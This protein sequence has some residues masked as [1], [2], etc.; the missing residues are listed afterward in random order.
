MLA[1]KL[2]TFF[3]GLALLLP[4]AITFWIM[5]FRHQ[6]TEAELKMRQEQIFAE[7]K[8]EHDF[9]DGASEAPDDRDPV[10]AGVVAYDSM[11]LPMVPPDVWSFF[12]RRWVGLVGLFC[13][14]IMTGLWLLS[15][16][17]PAH[18][19]SGSIGSTPQ[20][21]PSAVPASTQK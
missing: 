2:I 13:I 4:F 5:A 18:I 19:Y 10:M 8:A 12:P 17:I 15:A 16:F 20:P 11:C 14:F 21:E 6:D 3:A 7:L 1:P 9:N